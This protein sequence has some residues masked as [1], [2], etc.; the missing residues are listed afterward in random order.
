MSF[1]TEKGFFMLS[2]AAKKEEI[3]RLYKPAMLQ[4]LYT[5]Q[6]AVTGNAARLDQR[7]KRIRYIA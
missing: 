5:T 3:A 2:A 4:H 1:F 7:W 6:V